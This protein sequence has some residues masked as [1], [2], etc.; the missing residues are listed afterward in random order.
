M[1]FKENLREAMEF[2]DIKPKELSDLNAIS[3]AAKAIS[4]KYED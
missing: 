2:Q 3:V 1:G 4:E